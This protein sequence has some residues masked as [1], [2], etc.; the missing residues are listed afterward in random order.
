MNK[1]KIGFYRLRFCLERY[2]SLSPARLNALCAILPNLKNV[3]FINCEHGV[4]AANQSQFFSIKNCECCSYPM[5]HPEIFEFSH[6]LSAWFIRPRGNVNTIFS[7]GTLL[8]SV[9]CTN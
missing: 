3:E 2:H 4:R 9:F 5:E 1:T 8:E 6:W 7:L